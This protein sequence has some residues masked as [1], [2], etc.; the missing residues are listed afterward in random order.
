MNIYSF[1]I[2]SDYSF[3]RSLINDQ[4]LIPSLIKR[5]YSGF[6]IADY[7]SLASLANYQQAANKNNMKFF[8]EIKV[9]V[10][11]EDLICDA[12][13][14]AKDEIAFNNILK[15]YIAKREVYN[16]KEFVSFFGDSIVIFCNSNNIF[17]SNFKFKD[18]VLNMKNQ[19]PYF[20]LGIEI[21]TKRQMEK[22]KELYNFADDNLI[23][24]VAVPQVLYVNKS[25]QDALKVFMA[26]GRGV[27]AVEIEDL[28]HQFL[29]SS[30][31]L[32]NVYRI[33]DLEEQQKIADLISFDFSERK[34]SLPIYGDKNNKDESL[35]KELLSEKIMELDIIDKSKYWDRIYYELDVIQELK[36]SSYFLIVADYVD[37][38]KK[39]GIKVGPGRG[40][41]GGSLCSY[42]LGITE[43]DPIK[44]N[45][46]FARFLNK[47]RKEMPDI[48]I[49]FQDDRRGEVINYIQSKYGNSN[50]GYITTYTTYKP[51]SLIKAVGKAMGIDS[52][53]LEV[54]VK[55]L[56]NNPNTLIEE[57]NGNPKFQK[58][59]FDVRLK[60]MIDI[61]FCI[62]GLKSNSSIHPAGIIIGSDN[63]ST[64]I[65]SH[66]QGSD[67][68]CEMEYDELEKHNFLKMDL[69]SLTN[70]KF[71][72]NI[73]NSIKKQYRKFDP[74]NIDYNDSEVYKT[75][76][77]CKLANI[78]QL[79][80]Q[81][82]ASAIKVLNPTC[83]DDLVALLALYRPGPMQNISVY[84]KRKQNKSLIKY[85]VPELEP[86]LNETN[87][88][89]VYQEQII[90]I[91]TQI[92]GM[93]GEDADLFRR[94][95]SK[96]DD[97]IVK[98]YREQ[99]LNGC[100]QKGLTYNQ[101][102]TL[103]DSIYQFS[104]YGFNKSHSV[105]YAMITYK[106]LYYKTKYPNVFYV[107]SFN[108]ESPNVN[109]K[110]LVNELSYF[111]ITLNKIDVLTS[112]SYFYAN[113]NIIY[114]PLTYVK[115]I[116]ENLTKKI[117]TGL[118]KNNT[119][120]TAVE[121]VFKSGDFKNKFKNLVHSGA[122][123]SYK[124][125]REQLLDDDKIESIDSTL[126]LKMELDFESIYF[127]EFT[128]EIEPL[129]RFFK[130]K[131]ACGCAFNTTLA[132]IS[133]N[134][135][136]ENQFVVDEILYRGFKANIVNVED[137]FANYSFVVDRVD[138]ISIN[139]IVRYGKKAGPYTD[140]KYQSLELVRKVENE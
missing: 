28:H 126:S 41:A 110:R 93:S 2:V 120:E 7:N 55:S 108:S 35:L 57:V 34:G 53:I 84:G 81:G 33:E 73:E 139:D 56:S 121:L 50:V 47:F 46:S 89:I 71:I 135:E 107:E 59:Y 48:D 27:K 92:A 79:T 51:R 78:F 77:E 58:H 8:A 124:Y 61:C 74:N 113:D 105:A 63:L 40:S 85:I 140:N 133:G 22:V 75:L 94:A 86:I 80:S 44:Y 31:N 9:K 100:E 122:F 52:E 111:N 134:S 103:Y 17:S 21:Y 137:E 72:S 109:F 49:D 29:V 68:I 18:V 88:I 118:K 132:S 42:L 3:H 26:I 131:Y 4:K 97:K 32:S 119:I 60:P 99:F 83:F 138:N 82:M 128:G 87:G 104:S 127:E 19:I 129:S 125:L 13:V 101:R 43:V 116:D 95:M 62:E 11:F 115:G 14:I 66:Y 39:Q 12:I 10:A 96:K 98:D 24:T 76:Q 30:E 123:D 112:K 136:V 54:V 23:K 45:L 102:A 90:D 6:G 67:L 16:E 5:G 25:E 106:L 69:L 36:F 15:A 91:C 37:F 65:P 38:A 114:P 130:E 64:Q 117:N 1:N 70:L 20:Y